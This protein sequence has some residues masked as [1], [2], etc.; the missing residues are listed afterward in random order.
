MFFQ[1]K[2]KE[3]EEMMPIQVNREK[4]RNIPLN[5][6]VL[7]KKYQK[8]K[9]SFYNFFERNTHSKRFIIDKYQVIIQKM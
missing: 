9:Y 3:L 1:G 5:I 4:V 8:N 7:L 2:L 6:I